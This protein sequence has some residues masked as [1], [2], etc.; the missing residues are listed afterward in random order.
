MY[1]AWGNS[2]ERRKKFLDSLLIQNSRDPLRSILL[3]GGIDGIALCRQRLTEGTESTDGTQ[4]NIGNSK[5]L[6]PKGW[7]RVRLQTTYKFQDPNESARFVGPL[8]DFCRR[9]PNMN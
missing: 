7:L 9:S 1:L 3:I 4:M 5:Y 8:C 2:N 6:N